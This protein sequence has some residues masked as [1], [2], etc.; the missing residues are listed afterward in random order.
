MS[1]LRTLVGVEIAVNQ[2]GYFFCLFYHYQ[3]MLNTYLSQGF[4]QCGDLS[5]VVRTNVTIGKDSRQMR[6]N[7]I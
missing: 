2:V 3:T 7:Q 1:Y 5:A 4:A 6:L